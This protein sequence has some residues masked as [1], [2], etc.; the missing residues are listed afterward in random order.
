MFRSAVQMNFSKQSRSKNVQILK[1]FA[2][3]Q[4]VDDLQF[5]C[6]FNKQSG[7]ES[8]S[9]SKIEVKT[10]PGS[11]KLILDPQHCKILT[12]FLSFFL[13]FEIF[14]SFSHFPYFSLPLLCIFPPETF[15]CCP[16]LRD[17]F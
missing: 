5:K 13:L 11:E 10:R 8:E 14:L 17:L 15:R 16:L 12:L 7:S 6:I 4:C 2:F 3:L 1:K 9:G